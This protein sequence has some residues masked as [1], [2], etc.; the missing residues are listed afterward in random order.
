MPF[1]TLL[2]LADVITAAT[3]AGQP[4]SRKV[5]GVY[6]GLIKRFGSEFDVLMSAGRQDIAKEA[7]EKVADAVLSIREGKAAVEPGYDGVYGRLSIG[8]GHVE[9]VES[10][11]KR[12]DGFTKPSS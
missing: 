3:G 9:S 7:G 11:Q 5:W 1:R 8:K 2:P 4:G 6:N 10:Q 12:L